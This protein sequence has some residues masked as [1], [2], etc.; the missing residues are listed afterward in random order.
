VQRIREK[1]QNGR[2][3]IERAHADAKALMAVSDG[4]WEEG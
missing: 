3:R 2:D 1:V 4:S